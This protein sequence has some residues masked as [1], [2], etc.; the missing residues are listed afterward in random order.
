MEGSRPSRSGGEAE[1]IGR[2]SEPAGHSDSSESSA[3]AHYRLGE[4]ALKQ[5]NLGLAVRAF[6]SAVVANPRHANS[7]YRLGELAQHRG[8][9][10][11]ATTA[12]RRALSSRPDHVSAKRRLED[13]GALSEQPSARNLTVAP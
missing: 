2:S 13:I 1:R 5:N 7:W 9:L 8:A 10:A 11:E 4:D 3:D 12:Y 6:E